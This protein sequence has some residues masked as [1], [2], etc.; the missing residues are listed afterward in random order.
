MNSETEAFPPTMPNLDSP[1]LFSADLNNSMQDTD[2]FFNS[3][4]SA[5][6][7]APLFGIDG[8]TS[9]PY[10]SPMPMKSQ[11]QQTIANMAP[12]PH[13]S[14][15]SP[16]SS[17]QDSSSDSSGRHKRKS[18]SRSSN[19]ELRGGDVTM[20]E[21]YGLWKGNTKASLPEH[22]AF[23]MPTSLG[24]YQQFD[25][26]NRQLENDFFDFESAASSPSPVATTHNHT[27][28]GPRHIA[29][30]FR[31][32]PTSAPTFLPQTRSS[33]VSHRNQCG[34]LLSQC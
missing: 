5:E 26:S 20:T 4:L 21:E 6:S 18:S 29:I 23:N 24:S 32:S 25:Y 14:S 2:L 31:D 13:A 3:T 30:P 8:F 16:D 17:M 19:A 1:Q 9:S 15:A 22:E 27:Y 34:E 12:H 10:Q 11:K 33:M 28:N 7:P